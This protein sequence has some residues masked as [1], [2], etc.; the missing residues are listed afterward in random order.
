MIGVPEGAPVDAGPAAGVGD[1]GRARHR[2]GRPS[3]WPAQC[4]RC[5]D[6]VEDTAA[7]RPGAVRLPGQH[8]RRDHRARTRSAA[9]EG[10]CS[11][12]SRWSATPWC[13]PCRWTPLCRP[14]CAGLCADCG[15]RLDDLPADHTHEVIDPRWAGLAARFGPNDA[16]RRLRRASRTQH[17]HRGV[18]DRGR[19]EA[20]DVAQQHPVPPVAVEDHAPRP[21]SPCPNR[22]CGEL[23]LPHTACPNC[24]QYDGRQVLAV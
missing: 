2:H 10:D 18:T 19:P 21:W 14:D 15:E 5:L 9:I 24:G 8:H 13:W 3:R 16:P 23:K 17:R 1:R 11:T 6:P 7:R 22:A 12:S 4:A 20:E